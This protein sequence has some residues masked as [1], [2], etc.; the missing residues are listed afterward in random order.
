VDA[1][2]GDRLVIQVHGYEHHATSAQRSKDIAHDAELRLRG[3]TVLR[4]SY[5][6]VVHESRLVEATIR[7]AV[8][9]GLHLAA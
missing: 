2:I 7:R 1:L 3:Y 8:A 5:A 9:A 4:F 6:Q